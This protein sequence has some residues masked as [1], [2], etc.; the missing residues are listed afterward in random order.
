MNPSMHMLI[1]AKYPILMRCRIVGR[2]N[3]R[4]GELNKHISKIVNRMSICFFIEHY[5]CNTTWG[6]VCMC[7]PY[8]QMN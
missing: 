4:T 6:M 2:A 3:I 8:I 1:K 7:L 5:I